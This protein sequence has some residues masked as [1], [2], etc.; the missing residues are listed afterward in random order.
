MSRQYARPSS[1]RHETPGGT[2]QASG[3]DPD[4]DPDPDY[5]HKAP[6]RSQVS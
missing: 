3:T 1:R 5:I 2:G 4:P 6:K